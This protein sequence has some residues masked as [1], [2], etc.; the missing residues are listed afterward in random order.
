MSSPSVKERYQSKLFPGSSHDWA[1]QQIRDL[2]KPSRVLDI[3]PGSGVIGSALKDQ[4]NHNLFAVEIDLPAHQHLKPIYT[5]IETSISPYEVENLQFD[6]VLMLDVLEHML[7][8]FA[9]LTRL[10]KL[11]PV[12][13]RALIS[14]PNIAHWSIRLSLLFGYFEYTN[15][16]LLDR[17]HLQFFNRRRFEKLINLQGYRPVCRSAS[18]EPLELIFPESIT[19]NKIFQTCSNVRVKFAQ[20]LPGLMAYQHLALIQA[21]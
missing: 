21:V 8:P 1:L 14:V 18:I 12:G 16:G 9:F 2:P 5:R 3:G 7:D 6:L 10:R 4:G 19:Q 17:T 20:L 11:M 15:R 13:A